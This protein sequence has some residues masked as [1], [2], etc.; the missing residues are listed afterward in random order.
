EILDRNL[1]LL[2]FIDSDF[3]V[4]NGRL[5]VHYGIPGISGNAFR[6][7]Q[8]PPWS[9]RGGVLAQAGV[10]MATSNGMVTSPVRRGAFILERFLGLPPGAP[11]PNVPALDKVPL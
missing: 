11:P 9:Q 4:V 5:A 7:V 1:S 2:N 8:L 3:A 6:R 10:L